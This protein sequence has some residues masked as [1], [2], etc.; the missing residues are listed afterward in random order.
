MSLCLRLDKVSLGG[1]FGGHLAVLRGPLCSSFG[2]IAPRSLRAALWRLCADSTH[3]GYL[4]G[5]GC[6]AIAMSEVIPNAA[7]SLLFCPQRWLLSLPVPCLLRILT[8]SWLTFLALL[9]TR[10]VATNAYVFSYSYAICHPLPPKLVVHAAPPLRLYRATHAPLLSPQSS[11]NAW[12]LQPPPAK[13]VG[14]IIG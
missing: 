10:C 12:V 13:R 6:G 4:S 5:L 1:V 8:Q 7:P 2:E 9:V 14:R 3:S 11:L